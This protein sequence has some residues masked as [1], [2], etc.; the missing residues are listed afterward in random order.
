MVRIADTMADLADTLS[1]WQQRFDAATAKDEADDAERAEQTRRREPAEWQ[2]ALDQLREW[3]YGYAHGQVP[4][5][6]ED[7]QKS[8]AMLDG[9]VAA[10]DDNLRAGYSS[11]RY[12]L[13][14]LSSKSPPP[15]LKEQA[16][17]AAHSLA[18]PEEREL[19]TRA[20]LDGATH[21]T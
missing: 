16:E 14:T 20:W 2:A 12:A 15:S 9:I 21:E 10:I 7:R 8:D 13:E 18:T 3:L 11:L 4:M 1:G 17:Q 19:Y 6:E 5:G